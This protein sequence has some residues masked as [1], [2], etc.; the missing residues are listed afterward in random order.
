MYLSRRQSQMKQVFTPVAQIYAVRLRRGSLPPY[1]VLFTANLTIQKYSYLGLKDSDLSTARDGSGGA[2]CLC[3]CK[4]AG[5][6]LGTFLNSFLRKEMLQSY[7]PPVV[8]E[9]QVRSMF[10]NGYRITN[11]MKTKKSHLALVLV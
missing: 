6:L 1:S 11:Y 7:L 9:Q 10:P 3:I 4:H 8:E 2:R 5:G